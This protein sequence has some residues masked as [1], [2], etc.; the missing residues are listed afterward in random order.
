M[1]ASKPEQAYRRTVRPRGLL[2]RPQFE[3][4]PPVRLKE[5]IALERGHALVHRRELVLVSGAKGRAL[6]GVVGVEGEEGRDFF[7]G[8]PREVEVAHVIE[9][10]LVGSTESVSERCSVQ[11]GQMY[12]MFQAPTA[13]IVPSSSESP[14]RSVRMNGYARAEGQLTGNEWD[15]G[16]PAS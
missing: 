9:E 12:V 16:D 3:E 14:M 10:F 4:P 15:V 13:K 11:E 7:T 5:E 8:R 1:A 2:L 6:C